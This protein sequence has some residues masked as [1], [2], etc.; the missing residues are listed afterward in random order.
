MNKKYIWLIIPIISF[1]FLNELIINNK[2]PLANDIVAHEPIKQ[3]KSST[4]EYPHWFPN[5]FSGMPSYGGFIITGG[6]PLQSILNFLFFNLGAKYWFHFSLGGI[7]MFFLIRYQKFTIYSSLFGGI[8]Y[9]ITPY[10]FGLINAGHNNKIMA[11]A[12]IPW[13][14][15]SALYLFKNRS[16]KSVFI[17]SLVSAFQLWTKHPQIFYYTWMLIVLWWIIDILL[18]SIGKKLNIKSI[19]TSLALMVLSAILAIIMV[20]DPYYDIYR[21]QKES[22]R[23]APSVLDKTG[24]SNKGTNWEYATQWSF[25][26]A[27]TISFILPY[28]YGLQNFSVTNKNNPEKFMKQAAYWGYMPF[29]QS[30]HYV[31]LLV[32]IFSIYSLFFS[33][34]YRKIKKEELILWIIAIIFLIIGFGNHFSLIFKP[35]FYFAPYFSKFRVPSMIYTLFALLLP[36]LAVFGLEKMINESDKKILFFDCLKVFGYFIAPI[37]F[38]LAFGESILSFSSSGDARFPQYIDLVKNIRIDLFSKGLMLALFLSGATLTSIWFYSTGKISKHILSIILISILSFDLWIINN[39]FLSLKPSKSMADQFQNT[40]EILFMKKDSSQF[41]IFPADDI[42]SNRYGYWNI[43]SIGGYRAVKLRNYQ[44]LMDAGGFRRPQVLNMLNV[45]YLITR[46]RVRNTSF[47]QL[48]KIKNLYENLDVLPRAW[49]VGSLQSVN[50]QKSSLSKVMDISFRPKD[51]AVIINYDGPQLS[52]TSNGKVEIS[53]FSPNNIT[54]QCH[55]N[56]GALLVLSEIYYKPGWR[57]KIDGQV[58]PIYQTN[59]VLRSVYVSDG[60]HDV[61]FYYDSS[62]WKLAKVV[63]RFSF[64]T[65]LIFL[66]LIFF[67]EKINKI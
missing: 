7:G 56:S 29:T 45:K 50:D 18:S 55:T 52:G 9:S 1:I 40:P 35:L 25:H 22:N 26:P 3:W 21:F 44:D 49:F 17:L 43:E 30:T 6:H 14:T 20:S 24:E 64:F 10:L 4:S 8:A 62:D 5:L 57:C 19:F 39:E 60:S 15:L 12:F 48:S 51:T 34:K 46:K 59:H 33:I 16:I 32:I 13:L 61:E 36:F 11:C 2:I 37:L 42:G 66:G 23:G 54:I 65:V 28:Y 63:S 27:E 31:G 53:S 47:K 58:T 41:R 38:L 67:R